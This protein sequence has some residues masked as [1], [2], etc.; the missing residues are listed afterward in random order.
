MAYNSTASL[1]NSSQHGIVQGHWDSISHLKAWRGA[2]PDLSAR[3]Q[4]FPHGPYTEF[5]VIVTGFQKQ[6]F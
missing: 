3:F 6:A 2:Q 5:E 4:F 1:G